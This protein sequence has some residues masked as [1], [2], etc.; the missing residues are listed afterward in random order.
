MRLAELRKEKGYTQVK[1][2]MLTGIDQSNISKMELGIIE[3]NISMLKEFAKIF[4]T[5]IDY[6]TEFTDERKP[7]PRK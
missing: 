7:Y 5:S 4:D 2:Q 3:P 1:M 6:L